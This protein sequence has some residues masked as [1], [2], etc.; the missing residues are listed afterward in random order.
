MVSNYYTFRALAES[1]S[2]KLTGY[3]IDHAFSQERDEL[4]FSFSGIG[5]CLIV[6]CR[7]QENTCYVHQTFT[8]AKRN[9]TSLFPSSYGKEVL[10]VSHH[11][12]DR[13]IV[14]RLE[15][16]ESLVLLFYR[17]K[18]NVLHLDGTANITDAFRHAKELR[19][20]HYVPPQR[21]EPVYDMT[22]FHTSLQKEP[23]MPV[24]SILRLSYPELG[25][26]LVHE[27]LARA[28][29]P[30]SATGEEVEAQ[31]AARFT[32]AL[33]SVFADLSR[34][35]F[36]VYSET[37]GLPSV[38]SLIPLRHLEEMHMLQFDDVH[39]A[40]RFFI[41]RRR[42]VSDLQSKRA[43]L[44][45]TL[46]AQ[47]HKAQRTINA[48]ENERRESSRAS[49]YEHAGHLLLTL[50]APET[51]GARS[52]QVEDG[53]TL[54]LITLDPR[55][56]LLQNAQR[57]FE[58][59]K[60]AHTA[61]RESASRSSTV[62]TRMVHAEQLL[63]ALTGI[64]T[65]KELNALMDTHTTMLTEFGIGPRG[66]KH[67]EMPFRIFVVDGGFEVWAGK[68]STNNDLLTTR[69][70]KPNDLWF[71]ARG[72]SGSHVILRVA[73]SKGVPSKKAR[74]QAA[75]IAAYYSKMKKA[76]HVPVAMT[77]RKYVR[78][79]KGAAPG[80]VV[81]EREQTIFA[82]PALPAPPHEQRTAR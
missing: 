79:P 60:R 5:G 53:D 18:A 49:D 56:T 67:E 50:P 6:S 34:P 29:V 47:V 64:T 54:R 4:A 45:A 59:A 3:R 2:S 31:H 14:V 1:L 26:T 52:V 33:A 44:V 72:S 68:S 20:T 8:R 23:G 35:D 28:D 22:A 51:Q 80:T 42:A 74:D 43:P 13:M 9:T 41:S 70:A 75:G 24:R 17:S 12:G 62:S 38:F 46:Q 32:S 63:T 82:Q 39:E 71:H 21:G 36:L 57:Y 40:I 25:S 10:G 78:K 58:K 48:L 30:L 65:M 7:A 37:N 69:F 19:G 11:P 55:L 81:L 66:K 73:S 27:I 77:E 16:E 61:L 76:K 15:S